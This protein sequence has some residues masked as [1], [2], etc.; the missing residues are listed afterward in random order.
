MARSRGTSSTVAARV[1]P[2]TPFASTASDRSSVTRLP[3]Y[4][5][6]AASRWRRVALS[7][8]G[9]RKYRHAMR[10]VTHH[11]RIASQ[12]SASASD[13]TA[14][15]IETPKKSESQGRGSQSSAP[16]IRRRSHQIRR[17][18]HRAHVHAAEVLADDAERKELRTRKDRDDGR[19]E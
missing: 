5:K 7:S 15:A 4:L 17:A 10:C 1:G 8:P 3:T 6:P 14:R 16:A 18:V 9:H 2:I 12:V 13:R 19:E 11:C